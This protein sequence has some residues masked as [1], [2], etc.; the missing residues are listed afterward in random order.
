[1]IP[2]GKPTGLGA[3]LLMV[4][5]GMMTGTAAMADPHSETGCWATSMPVAQ[6]T[7]ITRGHVAPAPCTVESGTGDAQPPQRG[8]LTYDRQDNSLRARIDLPP[9]TYLGRVMVPPSGGVVRG[10]PAVLVVR[11]GAVE[12]TRTVEALQSAPV[13]GS[14]F[15]R[16]ADGTVTA[17]PVVAANP[18]SQAP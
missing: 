17:A 5:L 2:F 9:G 12:I 11:I 1:M 15:V 4:S 7:A 6:G 18:G 13:G 3:W 10:E 14:V 16:D 8:P